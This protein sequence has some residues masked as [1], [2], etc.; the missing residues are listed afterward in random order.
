MQKVDGLKGSNKWEKV[1]THF[2]IDTEGNYNIG[3][4]A[5]TKD[6][7]DFFIDSVTVTPRTA[8]GIQLHNSGRVVTTVIYDLN[9]RQLNENNL[10]AL[11]PGLYMVV[12]TDERGLRAVRKFTRK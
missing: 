6:F 11:K 2:T 10:S 1:T 4:Y 9:G 8:D 7:C 12:T 3:F 5:T